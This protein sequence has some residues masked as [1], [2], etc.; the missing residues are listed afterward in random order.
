MRRE[1]LEYLVTNKMMEIK[2]STGKRKKRCLMDEQSGCVSQVTYTLK[3][4]R[5][6]D[7]LEG[8]YHL[9]QRTGHRAKHLQ[10]Y[11]KKKIITIV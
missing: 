10:L 1:K 3:E 8:H 2:R 9:S 11:G 6:G 4:M 5:D 7:F